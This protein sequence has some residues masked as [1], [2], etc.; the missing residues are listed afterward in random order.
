MVSLR[1]QN[2]IKM[3]QITEEVAPLQAGMAPEKPKTIAQK[4][5]N[6]EK[7]VKYLEGARD[8]LRG[9]GCSRVKSYFANYLL[10]AAYGFASSKAIRWA[11]QLNP[12]QRK[13][14]AIGGGVLSGIVAGIGHDL[15]V[16]GKI[17]LVRCLTF[18]G[19]DEPTRRFAFYFLG[20]ESPVILEMTFRGYRKALAKV[21]A[22][23]AEELEVLPV[24]E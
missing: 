3:K 5:F 18:R 17:D 15:I 7:A 14:I 22:L 12:T 1:G 11:A 24:L 16:P 6:F 21:R 2:L 8:C 10:G 9:I 23:R 19:C 20:Y 13:K 4:M